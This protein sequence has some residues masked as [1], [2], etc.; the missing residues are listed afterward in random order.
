MSSRRD[1]QVI[2]PIFI[3]RG[4]PSPASPTPRSRSGARI[5]GMLHILALHCRLIFKQATGEL[6]LTLSRYLHG[7]PAPKQPVGDHATRSKVWSPEHP[8]LRI[9]SAGKG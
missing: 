6:I 1:G 3:G 8:M 9:R 5:V 7:V 4:A 2:V